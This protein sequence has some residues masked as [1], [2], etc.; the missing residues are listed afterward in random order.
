MSLSNAQVRAT[1]AVSDLDRAREFYEFRLGL[2]AEP[3]GPE[4]VR[5]YACGGGTQLQVYAS[6]ENAGTA[7][8]TVASWS[9]D[10]GDYDATVDELIANGVE[11]VTYDGLE[12]DDRG[13]HAFGEHRVAWCEDPD[14]NVLAID[15][16]LSPAEM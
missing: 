16:G 15:N 4:M 3:G 14:G 5:I 6:P 8:A 1:V 9:V 13:V 7:T 11:L 2:K 10:A 12:A